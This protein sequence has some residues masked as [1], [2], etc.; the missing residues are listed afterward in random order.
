MCKWFQWS[1]KVLRKKIHIYIYIYIY[2]GIYMYRERDIY[3]EREGYIYP[4]LP[5]PLP[6]L[7]CMDRRKLQLCYTVCVHV[8]TITGGIDEHSMINSPVSRH[9]V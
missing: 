8:L 4:S 7:M 6:V 2:R 3:I 1:L 5:P 9:R